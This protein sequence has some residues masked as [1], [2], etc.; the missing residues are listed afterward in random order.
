VDGAVID[1]NRRNRIFGSLFGEYK[2][3]DG[4]TFRVN[5]GP[6]Y[7]VRRNGIFLGSLTGARSE[8]RPLPKTG[9][10]LPSRTRWKTF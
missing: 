4:L 7:Q 3:A 2:I 1:E 8:A 9:T 5:F 6:D 10:G